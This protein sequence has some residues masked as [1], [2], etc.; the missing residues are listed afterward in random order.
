M[1]KGRLENESHGENDRVSRTTWLKTRSQEYL[2]SLS[3]PSWKR[4]VGQI[5]AGMVLGS[6]LVKTG[7]ERWDGAIG[8]CGGILFLAGLLDPVITQVIREA[9]HDR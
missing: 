1:R 4:V 9:R 2:G 3:K 8:L 7:D 5:A 6:G